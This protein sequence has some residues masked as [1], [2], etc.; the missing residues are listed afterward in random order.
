MSGFMIVCSHDLDLDP[1]IMMYE[2]DLDIR[3]MDRHS[4]NDVSK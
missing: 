4:D 1:K 3:K 2:L